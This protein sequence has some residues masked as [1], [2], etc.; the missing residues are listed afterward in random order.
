MYQTKDIVTNVKTTHTTHGIA[1][2]TKKIGADRTARYVI[3]E[4]MMRRNVVK[5]LDKN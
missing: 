1:K 3:E 5:N 2:Y 4:T